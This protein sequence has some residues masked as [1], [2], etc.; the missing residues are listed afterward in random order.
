MARNFQKLG[1]D[2]GA[3]ASRPD[4]GTMTSCRLPLVPSMMVTV[5]VPAGGLGGRRADR[6]RHSAPGRRRERSPE[7][8]SP[9]PRA[10]RPSRSRSARRRADRR[11]S[12][13]RAR[14]R[15]RTGQARPRPP[16]ATRSTAEA[17]RKR[18]CAPCRTCPAR[19]VRSGHPSSRNPRESFGTQ[20]STRPSVGQHAPGPKSNRG[21]LWGRPGTSDRLA[22]ASLIAAARPASGSAGRP[23]SSPR[24]AADRPPS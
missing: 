8:C 4:P 16:A 20:I 23:S 17:A 14:T 2:G 6:G 18:P 13:P 1:V 7:S 21:G 19:E 22:L 15:Q 10:D 24:R 5:C 12:P 11:R 3:F 9:V